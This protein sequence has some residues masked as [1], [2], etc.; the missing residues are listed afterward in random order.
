MHSTL[1]R[2]IVMVSA[3]WLPMLGSAQ[4]F[5]Q[6]SPASIAALGI[7]TEAV[8]SG[9]E[10]G[11]ASAT[12]VVIAPPGKSYSVTLPFDATMIEPLVVPGM[13]V[14]AGQ[15]I[16]V[17]Q[18]PEYAS[19]YAELETLRIEAEHSVH[20]FERAIELHKLGLHSDQE[21]EEADHEMEAAQYSL[22]AAQQ[23]LFSL[24]HEVGSGRFILTAPSDGLV[25]HVSAQSG[26]AVV[27]AQSVVSLFEG[28]AYWA[29]IQLPETKANGVGIGDSVL[30]LQSLNRGVVV[31]VD[32]EIDPVSRSVEILVEMPADVAWRIG[33]LVTA[34][35]SKDLSPDA[36]T[37][38]T[39]SIVRIGNELFVFVSVEDGF[40]TV[41][42]TIV[43]ESRELAVVAGNLSLDDQVAISGLAALKNVI[44]GG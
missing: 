7:E 37:V 9:S 11:N 5:V 12:A 4:V 44:E 6:V 36:L 25:T 22:A 43:S 40:Q 42:I 13:N 38:P 33:Q 39:Q 32:P 2:A 31:A 30:F 17:L 24:K 15:N 16:A 3:L 21:L 29:S 20:I 14:T 19:A 28:N 1:L 26:Q 35:I 41:P 18:S 34:T 10:I 23:R 27:S 8:R